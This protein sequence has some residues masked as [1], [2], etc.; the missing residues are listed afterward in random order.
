MGEGD[1]FSPHPH[2]ENGPVLPPPGA[3][4]CLNG[5][6]CGSPPGRQRADAP[7]TPDRL[8]GALGRNGRT[9]RPPPA[10]AAPLFLRPPAGCLHRDTILPAP[11][12]AAS[13][14]KAP[15]QT[16]AAARE[17]ATPPS[18]PRRA[19]PPLPGRTAPAG[20]LPSRKPPPDKSRRRGPATPSP[21]LRRGLTAPAGP[22]PD[23]KPSASQKP[24]PHGPQARHPDGA[25]A[26]FTSSP[27]CSP[28]RSP[29]CRSGARSPSRSPPPR[30]TPS[31]S[32]P[33]VPPDAPAG[34]VRRGAPAPFASPPGR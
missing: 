20:P 9:G 12:R 22:L 3:P 33:P 10:A 32:P 34:T 1:L 17:L 31:R 16:K 2:L 18:A 27:S 26:D 28:A 11:R 4:L 6:S 7:P 21:A 19:A 23:R 30:Q 5:K 14:P 15:R 29:P 25:P 13:R 24:P 8:P